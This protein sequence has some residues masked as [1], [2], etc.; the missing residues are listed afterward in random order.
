M[1]VSASPDTIPALPPEVQAEIDA[2]TS[3]IVSQHATEKLGKLDA[4]AAAAAP[5]D[6]GVEDPLVAAE[7]QAENLAKG[8]TEPAAKAD[9]PAE[10]AERVG[11]LAQQLRKQQVKLV[12]EQ[13]ALSRQRTEIQTRE[14]RAN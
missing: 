12:S 4:A 13:Q 3:A 6:T 8:K 11:K 1:T 14:T 10:E 9:K 5:A 2:G 7:K